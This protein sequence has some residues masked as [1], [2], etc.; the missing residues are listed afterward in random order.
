MQD[1]P[2]RRFPRAST[3]AF[4]REARRVPGFSWFDWL[5]GYVYARWPYL[6]IGIGTGEHWLARVFRPLAGLLGRILPRGPEDPERSTVA[7]AYH[8]KVVGAL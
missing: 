8:G 4:T 6:Y 7:D 2:S 3:R 1:K 5:H